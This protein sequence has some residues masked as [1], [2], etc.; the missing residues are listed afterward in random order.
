MIGILLA[1]GSG[2]RM[3]PLTYSINKQ[4]LP[5]YNKPMIY[6][7]LSMLMLAGIR[8]IILIINKNYLKSYKKLFGNGKKIGIKLT[9][10]IQKNPNGIPECFKITKK[11]I[12]NKKV[13]LLLG[14][15]FF[16]GQG[17][18][19]AMNIGKS[20]DKGAYFYGYYVKNPSDYAVVNFKGKKIIDIQEKPNKPKSNFAIPGL[21]FLMGASRNSLSTGTRTGTS[22][23]FK[24]TCGA[25][26]AAGASFVT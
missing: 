7:S 25:G 9:Y 3:R 1:G 5:V 18:I 8:N 21:Y 24:M 19:D 11:Y 16:F 15:N 2:K 10:V 22:T 26:D 6:Y 4:L 13:C 23:R 14:D 20:I 12:K 17:I